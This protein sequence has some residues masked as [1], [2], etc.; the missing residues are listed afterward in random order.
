M[1]R[2]AQCEDRAGTDPAEGEEWR[3]KE[4][5][6]PAGDNPRRTTVLCLAVLACITAVFF[7]RV[8][9]NPDKA[10]VSYDIVRAHT[11][12]RFVQWRSFHEYGR[13]PLW[14]PTVFCGKSIVGDSLPALLNPPQWVFWLTPSP[15]LFGYV[16]WFYATIGAWGMFLFARKKGCTAQGAMLAAIVFSLGGKTAGH[17]FAGH[18]EVLATVL[19]LPW[20]M[21]AAETALDRPSAIKAGIL[22]AVLALTATCGSVQ[23]V[24]WHF[25]FVGAYAVLWLLAELPRRGRRAAGR[26]LLCFSAGML[27]FMLFA[28]PWWFPIVRQTAMLS[29][30][31]RGTHFEFAASFSPAWT[32]LLHLV[33][34]FHAVPPLVQVEVVANVN[35]FWEK[36]LYLGI[37]PLVLL[38]SAGLF[39]GKRRRHVIAITALCALTFLVGMGAR[40]PL[41]WLATESI[42]GFMLFRC[43]GRLF[44][45]TGFLAA[46]LAGMAL[47]REMPSAKKWGLPAVAAA[48][49]AAACLGAV[50][51]PRAAN[52]PLN[53]AWLPAAILAV[54][55]PVTLL[56][57]R[58]IVATS[59]WR[60]AV[61]LLVCCDLFVVWQDH[62]LLD[63]VDKPTPQTPIAEYLAAQ[64][65]SED[66]RVQAPKQLISQACAARYGLEIMGG[67][68][69][70]VYGRFL[71]L[72]RQIWR[73]DRSTSTLLTEHKARDVRHSILL[74]LMNVEYI[75]L[76]PG[77]RIPGTKNAVKVPLEGDSLPGTLYRRTTAMPRACIVPGAHPPEPGEPPLKALCAIDPK[78]ECLTEGPSHTGG[79][80]FRPLDIEYASPG[81]LTLRFKSERGG[82]VLLS[83]AWHPDWRATDNG[84]AATLHRVNYNFAGVF[85]DPGNHVLRVWYFPWDFYAGCAVA[86]AAWTLLAAGGL[87]SLRAR[88]RKTAVPLD[89]ETA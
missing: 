76:G 67:Y 32:D 39:A 40:T 5:V 68:H 31:A 26:S 8:L 72:Y 33:W 89:S 58:G 66:F 64:R 87:W 47:P 49:L 80:A 42:P 27:S 81:D 18:V 4:T 48:V 78:T 82:V 11:E 50:F 23:F 75:V 52:Q 83:Q 86:A 61:V 14:D 2:R 56:W 16:L 79:D 37:V 45:Y 1:R 62:I 3:G 10:L 28:A 51:L 38:L 9:L 54:F 69:P 35:T 53:H 77:D 6:L 55:L 7:Y 30:R 85:V 17:L 41:F 63:A 25:L 34:P 19:C 12:Y 74:D 46:L 21:L 13:F 70:G 84:H 59:L 15:A 20:V 65:K 88:T 43:P 36:T 60:G 24:Y 44:F 73:S 57:L 71:D 29:A 22:G